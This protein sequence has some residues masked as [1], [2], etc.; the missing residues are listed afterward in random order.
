MDTLPLD[1]LCI[2]LKLLGHHLVARD[3]LELRL[4]CRRWLRGCDSVAV[5]L[6]WRTVN[7]DLLTWQVRTRKLTSFG[8]VNSDPTAWQCHGAGTPSAA[9]LELIMFAVREAVAHTLRN[10]LPVAPVSGQLFGRPGTLAELRD[11]K[12]R[13]DSPVEPVWDKSRYGVGLRNRAVMLGIDVDFSHAPGDE[14]EA[15]NYSDSPSSSREEDDDGDGDEG[16]IDDDPESLLYDWDDLTQYHLGLS[17]ERMPSSFNYLHWALGSLSSLYHHCWTTGVM[18]KFDNFC[19]EV[20]TAIVEDDGSLIN[21]HCAVTGMT[22]LM[23]F[24]A[25]PGLFWTEFDCAPFLEQTVVPLTLLLLEKGANLSAVDLSGKGVYDFWVGENATFR[26]T[27]SWNVVSDLLRE[28]GLSAPRNA[29]LQ[30][31]PLVGDGT[32]YQATLSPFQYPLSQPSV[33]ASEFRDLAAGT[34]ATEE[35]VGAIGNYL[36]R[37]L[38]RLVDEARGPREATLHGSE[39]VLAVWHHFLGCYAGRKTL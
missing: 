7:A 12:D 2:I 34:D 29:F 5:L 3:A 18:P 28:K 27:M 26:A 1:V 9:A 38:M 21:E 10:P 37:S 14:D 16:A 17:E 25:S 24:F 20:R 8:L 31:A 32:A 4:V 22:P 35:E 23:C 15:S 19:A 36:L 30:K 11:F 39:S 6:E 13:D 33:P